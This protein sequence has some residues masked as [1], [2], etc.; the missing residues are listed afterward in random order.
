MTGVGRDR[1]KDVN[2][3]MPGISGLGKVTLGRDIGVKERM[4]GKKSGADTG[5]ITEPSTPMTG[6]RVNTSFS[7]ED[8]RDDV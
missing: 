6:G 3:I 4:C 2:G 5:G 1:G 7:K 8:C